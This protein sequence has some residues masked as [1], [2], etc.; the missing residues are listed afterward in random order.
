MN[1]FEIDDS[2]FDSDFEDLVNNG[3]DIQIVYFD[4]IEQY[5]QSQKELNKLGGFDNNSNTAQYIIIKPV[6]N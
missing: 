5:L 2:D 1:D 3:K 4:N 6:N